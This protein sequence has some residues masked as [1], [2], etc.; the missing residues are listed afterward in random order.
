MTMPIPTEVRALLEAPNFVHLTTLRADGTPRNWVVW[1]DL[2]D[3]LVLVCTG[4]DAWKAKDMVRDPR[5]SLSVVDQ[6]NPYRMAA[7]QGT[8]V[9]VRDDTDSKWMDAISMKY[10]GKPFPMRGEGRVCFAIAVEKA[11]NRTLGF[12]HDPSN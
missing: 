4:V 11:G 1:V 2:V 10:T 3:D 8:V 12:T 5:V 9:E 7:I 6:A